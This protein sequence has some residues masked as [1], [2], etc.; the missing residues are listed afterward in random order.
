MEK[1]EAILKVIND[2]IEDSERLIEYLR[3]GNGKK[4]EIIR[5]LEAENATLKKKID[6]LTF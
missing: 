5:K 6:N 1:Y 3:E 2:K 4:D